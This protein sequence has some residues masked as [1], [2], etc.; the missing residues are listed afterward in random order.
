L[1]INFAEEFGGAFDE[2]FTYYGAG[3][4]V[5]SQFHKYWRAD[6]GYEFRLKESDVAS[7]DFHRNRVTVGVTCS[8]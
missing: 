8:F 5:G 2:K 4:R 3:F 7:R 1:S 6:L